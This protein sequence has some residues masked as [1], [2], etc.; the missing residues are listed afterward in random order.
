MFRHQWKRSFLIAL[1]LI[2]ILHDQI[3]AEPA[4][5]FNLLQHLG[6]IVVIGVSRVIPEGGWAAGA[7]RPGMF[8]S[9]IHI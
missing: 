1:S 4:G 9:L 6:E 5:R 2:H 3:I 7:S 8:L